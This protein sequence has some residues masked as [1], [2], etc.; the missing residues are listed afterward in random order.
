[1][2]VSYRRPA[3]RAAASAL[4]RPVTAVT[5]VPPRAFAL[6]ILLAIIALTLTAC[7]AKPAKPTSTHAYLTATA[8]VNPDANGRASPVVVRLFQLRNDGEFAAADFFALYSKEKE[9]LASTLISREEYVLAPGETRT[10]DLAL[11]PQ[12]RV[13]GALAAFR[14]IRSA[15]WRALTQTPEKKLT[16]LLGKDSLTLIVDQDS[17]T[18]SVKD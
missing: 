1:M 12:A 15:H 5:G 2:S 10:I 7:A 17:V 8:T 6:L 14:D 18:L 3:L 11:D 16:D 4:R 9:T 13:I